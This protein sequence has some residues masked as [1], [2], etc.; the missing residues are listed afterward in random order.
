M[1]SDEATLTT[2]VPAAPPR[3][4]IGK[5]IKWGIAI[6]VLIA[7][8]VAGVMYWRDAQR[9]ISTDNSYVSANTVEVASQVSGPITRIYVTNQQTVKAGEPLFEIDSRP[10]ELA[11]ATAEAQL[12]MARQSTSQSSAAV[13]A[14]RAQV[15]Q[16]A[17][18]LRNAESNQRR[19]HDL[20]NRNLVSQQD[21]ES[22]RTQAETSAA[23]AKAADANLRQA[24]S[25]LG[26]A[27]DN[28]ASVRAAISHVDVA[29]LNLDY[30][31]IIAPT[32]GLIAN[33]SLRPGSTVQAGVPLFTIIS[34]DEFWV[35]ANFKETEIKRVK[36]GQ[37]AQVIVDMYRDHPFDG[38]VESL[39]GGSGQAFSLL[40][41]Q[42]ATGNWVK[43]TQRV[44]VK[45]RILNADAA[46]PLRIGTTATVH[47]SAE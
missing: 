38:M 15:A 32:S 21:A 12:E 7:G 17:A 30:T 45:I 8:I 2:N 20:L 22:I 41:A 43:V 5:I 6:L 16:R 31:K 28:N 11:L 25:A 19:A 33:F 1:S 42:N 37:K 4:A 10:Y 9:F 24:Q 3:L 44:P 47:V 34:S 14:A 26:K 13:E 36:P 23:V 40:P 18:E 35:D 29:K 46:H 39:S 27:G